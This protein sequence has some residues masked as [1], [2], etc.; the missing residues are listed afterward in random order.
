M[1]TYQSKNFPIAPKDSRIAIIHSEFNETLVLKLLQ[2]T[3]KGLQKCHIKEKN[4]DIFIVPGA[5]EIPTIINQLQKKNIYDG[6]IALGI[7]IRG[8]TNHYE[9]VT[10]ESA[11]GL[12][13]CSLSSSVPVINGILGGNN[14]TEIQDRLIKGKGFAYGIIK[15]I[16]LKKNI[17]N[18]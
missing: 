4:I 5:L 9:I 14:E 2:S 11:R 18:L 8:G 6:I 3:Q 16:Q 15:M 12:M 1:S 17:K 13:Q 7:V 10:E